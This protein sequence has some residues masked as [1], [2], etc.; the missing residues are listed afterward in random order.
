MRRI[1]EFEPSLVAFIADDREPD[2]DSAVALVDYEG[3]QTPK[4]AG[5]RYLLGI[6]DM[7]EVLD[8]WSSWRGGRVPGDDERVAAVLFYAKYDGYLPVT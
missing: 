6:R 1:D 5:M 8:T 3:P 7:K 4:P 2:A